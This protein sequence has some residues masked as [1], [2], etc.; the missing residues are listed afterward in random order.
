MGDLSLPAR[1]SVSAQG[2]MFRIA[3]KQGLTIPVL[4]KR[5][6]LK[7]STMEG[8]ANGVVMPAWAIGVL[9]EAGIPDDLLSLI[10][11]PFGRSVI[12]DDTGD[13]DLD[14]AAIDA[15]EFASE[16]QRARHPKSLGGIAIV[17]QEKV[18]I[19]PKLRKAK[20]ALSRAA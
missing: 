12:T 17:P 8:W 20:S 7:K 18:I 2:E 9:G 19:M 3:A 16:V 4:V 14:T 15:T 13:G 6:P 1:D 11:E 5:S 10:T